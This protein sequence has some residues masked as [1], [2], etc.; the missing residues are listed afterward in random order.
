M[1]A[2]D[3]VWA[4]TGAILAVYL[5]G[6]LVAR[7]LAVRSLRLAALVAAL[8]IL[9]LLLPR[10]LWSPFL[11]PLQ[12]RMTG[13]PLPLAD[14][15]AALP[16]AAL[17]VYAGLRRI[18]HRQ[19]EALAVI[20]AGPSTRLRRVVLP[21]AWKGL[22]LGLLLPALHLTAHSGQLSFDDAVSAGLPLIAGVFLLWS[23]WRIAR[24][25]E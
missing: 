8:L 5:T 11:A 7:L 21:A 3:P 14:L 19:I 17:P 10:E 18:D 23:A 12:A 20:G 13:L 4:L 16:F 1:I 6:L 9:P 24:G 2:P 22:L 25:P 15:L